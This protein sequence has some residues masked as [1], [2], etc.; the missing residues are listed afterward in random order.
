M[1]LEV[2]E[3][4]EASICYYSAPMKSGAVCGGSRKLEFRSFQPFFGVMRGEETKPVSMRVGYRVRG[5]K[6]GQCAMEIVGRMTERGIIEG[7][8]RM[9]NISVLCAS[10]SEELMNRVVSL[11]LMILVTTGVLFVIHCMG[12][13][14]LFKM[15]GCGLGSRPFWEGTYATLDGVDGSNR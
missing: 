6:D 15:I 9:G 2:G 4:R 14:N 13:V 10:A 3:N 12:I 1:A 8:E 7:R 5:G 11:L